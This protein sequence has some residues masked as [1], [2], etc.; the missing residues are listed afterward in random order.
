MKVLLSKEESPTSAHPLVEPV[1]QIQ[2]IEL[3]KDWYLKFVKERCFS[4]L[5]PAKECAHLLSHLKY[6]D[7]LTVMV[8]KDFQLP[9]LE[10]CLILGAKLISC[11]EK[12]LSSKSN[13]PF[14]GITESP[15]SALYRSAQSTLLQHLA[16]FM[17]LLPRTSKHQMRMH[18]LFSEKSFW[19][20]LFFIVPCT[21]SFLVTQDSLPDRNIPNDSSDDIVHLSAICCEKLQRLHE[22]SDGPLQSPAALENLPV[23]PPAMF[24]VGKASPIVIKFKE[25]PRIIYHDH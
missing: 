19:E 15:G 25:G 16:D 23:F 12:Y 20:I 22:M 1:I 10:Q 8:S 2:H 5:S 3:N 6:E 21:C 11:T 18:K 13:D 4:S 7:I 24:I 17:T 14:L 9:I